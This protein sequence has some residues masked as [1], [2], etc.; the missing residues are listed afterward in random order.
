MADC[1]DIRKLL[2]LLA[3]GELDGEL[4]DDVRTHAAGC[5][6][7]R[8][9]LSEY[10][11][12]ARALGALL[13]AVEPGKNFEDRVMGAILR[14]EGAGSAGRLERQARRPYAAVM[15]A[16]AAIVVAALMLFRSSGSGGEL[17]SGKL[18]GNEDTIKAG[19]RYDVE[20][21]AVVRLPGASFAWLNRLSAFSVQRGVLFLA[22]G[23]CYLK[24][25]ASS[26]VHT[27]DMTAEL[28]NARVY[29]GTQGG[30]EAHA[31]TSGVMDYIF[32]RAFA[33]GR[34]VPTLL[35]VFEGTA[36]VR[37]G[38]GR[39]RL[40]AGK[41]MFADGLPGP[42]PYDGYIAAVNREVDAAT[43]KTAGTR[44]QLER[45]RSIAAE[46]ER[47]LAGFREQLAAM[48]GNTEESAFLSERMELVA[49]VKEAHEKRIGAFQEDIA[50][51]FTVE[52]EER[53][54]RT[55]KVALAVEGSGEAFVILD[56]F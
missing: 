10:A 27:A 36:D 34:G 51:V 40:K 54:M 13:A 41:F 1:G 55:E 20:V 47:R 45:Y 9:A 21:P 52:F 37:S 39:Q 22:S 48:D 50:A 29:M 3:S 2:P 53:V 5:E 23:S 6:S 56:G 38:G 8:A 32:P 42:T 12:L 26:T 18:A 4:A 44:A 46:Y 28:A 15:A 11:G 30:G 19:K 14:P 24:T 35:V 7:C 16:A 17:V 31:G 25:A 43:R 33:E 49:A